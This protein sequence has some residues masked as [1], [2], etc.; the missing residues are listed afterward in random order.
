MRYFESTASFLAD[1][2][3]NITS[4]NNISK[5][6]AQLDT[7][8]SRGAIDDYIDALEETFLIIKAERYDLKGKEYLSSLEKYYLGDLGYRFWL[9]GKKAGDV[10]HRLEN[11]VFLELKRRYDRISVGK[12]NNAEIDFVASNAEETHYYQVSQTVLDEKTLERE[13]APLKS[14]QDSYLKTLLTLDTVG[15]GDFEGIKHANLIDWLLDE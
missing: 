12:F 14:I 4:I 5:G 7:K 15:L 1:N 3:G 11:V 8:I 13:L 6:L 10:E 9:L 2:I